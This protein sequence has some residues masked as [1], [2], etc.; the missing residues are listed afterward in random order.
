MLNVAE[1]KKDFPILDGNVHKNNLIYLDN[2]AT[3]QKP[4]SVITA[5]TRYYEQFNANVHSGVHKLSELATEEYERAHEKVARFIGAHCAEEIIFTK[6]ATEALNLLAYTL[7]KR[8]KAGEEI[9][10]TEMEHHSNL[11]P[12]QQIAKEKG[13]I[14]RF[15]RV[16]KDFRLDL[17]H[18]RSLITSK[19][20]IVSSTHMSNVLGTINPVKELAKLAHGRG[21]VMVV[22][23][24]QSI[25]HLPINVKDLDCDFFAF[26]GHKMLGPTGIGAL[27][28]KKA[29]LEKMDPFLFGGGMIREVTLH[30]TQFADLPAKFEAG[31]PSIAE[32]IGLSAAVD[33]LKK[34]GMEA[35]ASHEQELIRY[36]LKKLSGIPGITIYGPNETVQRGAVIAFN[37]EGIH[38]HDL[39]SILDRHGIA[40]RAGNH[41]TMP[42]M[43]RLGINGS[44][45][46]SFYLY[47]DVHDVDALVGAI[48]KAKTL[49]KA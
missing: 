21:A 20:K 27:Y 49:F 45:R 38:P 40:V 36:A 14:L 19:T 3:S 10:L 4:R 43:N 13:L 23:G 29:L 32:A 8:L 1:I 24:A 37:V 9:I 22:D 2:A 31:T 30:D 25:A 26:S 35:I 7:C 5:M 33:Y 17:D 16:G 39:A 18:A 46:A 44:A 47:N 48:G 6:N 12:W 11:V 41:C 28:G 42:L 15:I 34:I